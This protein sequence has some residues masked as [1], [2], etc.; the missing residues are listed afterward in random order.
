VTLD[1][2]CGGA[3]AGRCERMV[4]GKGGKSFVLR[5]DGNQVGPERRR[6]EGGH[7]LLDRTPRGINTQ[8]FERCMQRGR[9]RR[10]RYSRS[11]GGVGPAGITRVD[12]HTPV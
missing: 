4:R 3:L 11:K 2:F 9:R 1:V 5:R 7:S 8:S 10:A 12:S 6:Q